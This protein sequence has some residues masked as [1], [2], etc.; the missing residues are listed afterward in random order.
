MIYIFSV[1]SIRPEP[2]VRDP[3]EYPRK[4]EQHI[5]CL[6]QD[7][8]E[9]WFLPI[10]YSEFPKQK[11]RIG[12]WAGLNLV[13]PIIKSWYRIFL[14]DRIERDLSIWLSTEIARIFGI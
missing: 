10:F 11:E 7:N 1:L 3:R 13:Q 4:M 6:N 8:Q 2:L 9:E 12:K 5:F 14:L